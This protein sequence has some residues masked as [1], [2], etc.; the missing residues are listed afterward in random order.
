MSCTQQKQAADG[1]HFSQLLIVIGLL[2]HALRGFAPNQ[3]L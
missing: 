1:A 3:D 2:A